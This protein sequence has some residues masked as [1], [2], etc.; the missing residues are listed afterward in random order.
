MN[1]L[2]LDKED[3]E[4]MKLDKKID[5][6]KYFIESFINI[7]EE[8]YN[9]LINN[10][11]KNKSLSSE[12]AKESI[13]KLQYEFDKKYNELTTILIDL[14]SSENITYDDKV[15]KLDHYRCHINELLDENKL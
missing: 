15:K 8:Y 11:K 12:N 3:N 9:N 5:N 1:N 2:E 7:R 10:I 4:T 14:N 13:V 6:L